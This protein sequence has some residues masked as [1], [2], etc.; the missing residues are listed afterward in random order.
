MTSEHH[1]GNQ[2]DIRR[3]VRTIQLRRACES[4]V[5]YLPDDHGKT[6]SASEVDEFQRDV[7]TIERIAASLR[8]ER[9]NETG[10]VSA[11]TEFHPDWCS[12]PECADRYS[13]EKP[14]ASDGPDVVPVYRG[15]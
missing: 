1:P 3:I 14:Y 6:F 5:R 7:A 8:P 15:R 10:I 9:L 13:D 11:P 12:C 2:S 4:F